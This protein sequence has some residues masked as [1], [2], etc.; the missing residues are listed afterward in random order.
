MELRPGFFGENLTLDGATDDEVCVGDVVRVG[1]T[2][3]QVSVP[4]IPCA[5]LARRIGR[6]DWVKLTIRENRTGFYARILEPG[7]LQAGDEWNLVE[8]PNPEGSILALNHCLYLQFDPSYAERVLQMQGLSDWW[9]E[10]V[11]ERLTQRGTHWTAS[12]KDVE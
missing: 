4:R 7:T 8:R 1:S 9:K 12:M 11:S 6:K 3:I 5:N 2:V 10:Q